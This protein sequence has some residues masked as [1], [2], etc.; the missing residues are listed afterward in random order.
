M[1]KT[2]IRIKNFRWCKKDA[3]GPSWSA[4][5]YD[6]YGFAGNKMGVTEMRPSLANQIAE[7]RENYE[8]VDGKSF[9]IMPGAHKE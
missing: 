3:H 7:L 4:N 9:D 6:K 5:F 2:K 8:S 1:T